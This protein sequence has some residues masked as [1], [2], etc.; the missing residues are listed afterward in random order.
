VALA[1]APERAP[2]VP[3]G[4]VN[5]AGDWVYAEYADQQQQQ[6]LET[7]PP[8]VDSIDTLMENLSQEA[9]PRE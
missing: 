6:Q 3:D 7:P 8:P 2:L 5:V 4:V 9:P 1:N